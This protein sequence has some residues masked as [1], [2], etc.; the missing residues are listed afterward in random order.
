MKLRLLFVVSVW[1]AWSQIEQ[2]NLTGVV[3]DQTGAVV[4]GA[5]VLLENRATREKAETQTNGSGGYRLPFLK[6]GEYDLT[7]TKSGFDAFSVISPRE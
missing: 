1:T 7:V 4:P 2:A 6:A 3:N 5:A